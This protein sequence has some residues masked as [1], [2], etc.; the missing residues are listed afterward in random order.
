MPAICLN[1]RVR[2]YEILAPAKVNLTLRVLDRRSDGF[3]ALSSWMVP[4]SLCDRLTITV[5]GT[6]IRVEVPGRPELSGDDNLCAKAARAFERELGL[7]ASLNVVL[8]KRIP[9]AAGLGGG[10]SDAAAILRCL[11]HHHGIGADDPRL[12]A[13]ALA[14]GSD[15]PFFLRGEPA[16]ARGRGE[17]LEEA[18][19]FPGPL[20]L[21][22]VKPPFGVSAKEAYETLARLRSEGRLPPGRDEPLPRTLSTPEDV[23]RLLHNDLEAAVGSLHPIENYVEMLRDTG[24]IG[25]RMAGSG[26]CVF[27]LARDEAHAARCGASVRIRPNEV[28]LLAHTLQRGAEVRETDLQP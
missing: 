4:L 27:G 12:R 21:V 16:L 15:V 10:S 14:V 2:T 20:H 3:H 7:D 11:A 18:P 25:V 22:I 26:S 24:L 17:E 6:G 13:A 5:G 1:P 8:E 23:S 19:A 28:V 9:V